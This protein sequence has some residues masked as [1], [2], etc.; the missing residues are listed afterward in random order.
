MALNLATL[1]V[2]GLRDSTKC[3]RLFVELKN[4]G[5]NVTAVQETHFICAA[6]YRV[7]EKDFAVSSAYGSRNSAGV[8]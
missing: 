5:L 2:R 6:D 4:L 1:N 7:L 3:A 8:S